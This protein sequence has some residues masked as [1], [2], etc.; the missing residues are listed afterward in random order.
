METANTKKMADY[1]RPLADIID[2]TLANGGN[3]VIPSFAV[4]RTQEL[5]FFYPGNQRAPYDAAQS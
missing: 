4:G 2:N 5:L 1:T 3:V